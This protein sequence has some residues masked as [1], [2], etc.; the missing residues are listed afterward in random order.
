MFSNL[1]KIK[2]SRSLNVMFGDLSYYNR[3]T[4][5][6][7]YVPLAIGM[8]AQYAKQEFGDEIRVSLFKHIDKF[9]NKAE[10]NPPDVVGL[11]V[12][13]WNIAINQYLVKCIRQK[14]GR[15]VII[16]LGG[17]TI[18]SDEQEQHRY[19]STVF[20]EVDAI[21]LNEGEI[22][23]NNILRKILDNRNTV[24]KDPIE[25][26]SFLDGNR[27]VKGRPVGLTMDLSTMG[28][29]YLSGLLNEF[30]NSDYQPLIQTSR[31]FESALTTETP[32]PCN[33]PEVL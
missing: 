7:L 30:M 13:Y 21:I 20:P 32:T 16:V 11:S 3:Q 31:F 23:F 26:V 14:F 27:L 10:Q 1:K 22:S 8:I 28:S 12:Y 17:P 4:T 2:T 24:F 33:P 5:H 19:L 29:P 18:D 25:G 6:G 15:D 9:F